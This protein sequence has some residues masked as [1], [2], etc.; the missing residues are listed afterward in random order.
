MIPLNLDII[1]VLACAHTHLSTHS[2][3]HKHT[4]VP[5]VYTGWVVWGT[6]PGPDG[7]GD[8][9]PFL[10][11]RKQQQQYQQQQPQ[12]RTGATRITWSTTVNDSETNLATCDQARSLLWQIVCSPCVPLAGPE[13]AVL[14]AGDERNQWFPRHQLNCC[15]CC[16]SASAAAATL[17]SSSGLGRDDV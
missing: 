3:T 7:H 5:Q 9:G 14:C 10:G 8:G 2:G 17:A 6:P 13:R 11:L 4:C 16:L 15:C 1:L 12:L